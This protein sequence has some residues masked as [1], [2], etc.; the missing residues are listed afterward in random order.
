MRPVLLCLGLA[1]CQPNLVGYWDLTAWSV[2]R[3]DGVLVEGTDIGWIEVQDND[4]VFVLSRYDYQG[5]ERLIPLVEAWTQRTA[6]DHEERVQNWFLPGFQGQMDRTS[7]AP[8]R[9]EYT[10]TEDDYVL[11]P[12]FPT[13]AYD[14]WSARFV[15]ERP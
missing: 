9:I 15:M 3:P 10:T 7:T 14:G 6:V 2:T 13:E 4:E 5:G 12:T 1:A 8:L 11:L